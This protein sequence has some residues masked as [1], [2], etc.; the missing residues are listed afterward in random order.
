MLRTVPP[1]AAASL[2]VLALS[3]AGCGG[4]GH[5]AAKHSESQA[6]LG[7][8]VGQASG[9][10]EVAELPGGASAAGVQR[11]P[12][13]A[14]PSPRTLAQEFVEISWPNGGRLEASAFRSPALAANLVGRLRDER[15]GRGASVP[16]RHGAIVTVWLNAPSTERAAI[17][18]RCLT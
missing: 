17:L 11:L 3:L 18:D 10:T 16:E 15:T 5:P 13:G 9:A 14:E 1:A 12:S 2:T 4:G 6:V 8:I 7:C